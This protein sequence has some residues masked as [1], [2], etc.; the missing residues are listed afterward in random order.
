MRGRVGRRAR[1]KR[2]KLLLCWGGDSSP[3][4]HSS[5]RGT[6]RVQF[7]RRGRGGCR[8]CSGATMDFAA[9]RR[10]ADWEKGVAGVRR[11]T[12][13]LPAASC[14]IPCPPPRVRGDQTPARAFL[15]AGRLVGRAARVRRGS[16]LCLWQCWSVTKSVEMGG[17]SMKDGTGYQIHSRAG[18]SIPSPRPLNNQLWSDSTP[19]D[20]AEENAARIR[21]LDSA[22]AVVPW[23]AASQPG[24]Y[25]GIPRRHSVS[26]LLVIPARATRLFLGPCMPSSVSPPNPN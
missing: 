11:H 22:D 10:R 7:P 12:K 9:S 24:H 6:T 16:W 4:A 1:T 23:P 14:R 2:G 18:Y 26:A 25:R 15:S 20:R 17:R 13:I 3:A 21:R 8:E 5:S 19:A